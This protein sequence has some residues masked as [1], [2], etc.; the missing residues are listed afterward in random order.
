MKKIAFMGSDP[1]S[2]PLL[3][4]LLSHG[5]REYE[6]VAVYS[7]PDKPSGRGQRM[8]PNPIS[9]WALDRDLLLFRPEKPSEQDIEFLVKSKIDLVLV[10]AYGHILR[11]NFLDTP[12]LGCLNF[13]ASLLPKYRG[14]SPI[15]GA[16]ASGDKQTGVTLMKMV[17]KLS[18][19]LIKNQRI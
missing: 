1:I 12:P 4:Y 18:L 14:A 5:G 16:I 17:A 15:V 10:M 19:F 2:V 11:Q 13:H 3:E 6:L 8:S 9:Q 7:Q